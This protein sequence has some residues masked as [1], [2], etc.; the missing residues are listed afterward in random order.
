MPTNQILALLIAEREKL[1]RAIEALGGAGGKRR[2]RPPGRG[3]TSAT[4]TINANLPT[5]SDG[6][7]RPSTKTSVRHKR[8]LSAAGRKA[9]ADAARKRWAAIRAGKA[10]SPFARRKKR[11]AAA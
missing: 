2:G 10:P 4:S 1:N 7:Q 9:I 5:M 11:R 3:R 6:A 8:R